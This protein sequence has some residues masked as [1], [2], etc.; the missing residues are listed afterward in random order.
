AGNC[1]QFAW[2]LMSSAVRAVRAGPVT[3]GWGRAGPGSHLSPTSCVGRR[4]PSRSATISAS[5]E[6]RKL[7]D[8]R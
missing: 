2:N 7:V 5:F 6:R 4:L 8:R 1:R 3:K